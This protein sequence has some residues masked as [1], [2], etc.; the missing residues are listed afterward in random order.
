MLIGLLGLGIALDNWLS[1]LAAVLLPL[2]S[3]LVR[4]HHEESVL[5]GA[6]GDDYRDYAA[7]TSRLVPGVW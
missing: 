7:R 5:R 2:A 1:L 4:I 3:L 6:L